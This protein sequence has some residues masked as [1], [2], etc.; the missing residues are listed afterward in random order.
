[1]KRADVQKIADDLSDKEIEPLL[2]ALRVSLRDALAAE[3]PSAEK[4][5]EVLTDYAGRK[6]RHD[7]VHAMQTKFVAENFAE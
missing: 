7:M 4:V 2:N 5:Q 1:M 6:A 3:N